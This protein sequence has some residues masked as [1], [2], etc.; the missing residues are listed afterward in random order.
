MDDSRFTV[1]VYA[2]YLGNFQLIAGFYNSIAAKVA[3]EGL[4][5]IW[6]N[7]SFHIEEV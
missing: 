7:H 1:L 3:V 4:K 5:E 2:E 6:P